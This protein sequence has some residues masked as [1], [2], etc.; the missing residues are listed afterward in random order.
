M[1]RPTSE[2][3]AEA[4]LNKLGGAD[5]HGLTR[6]EVAAINLYTQEDCGVYSRL[7]TALRSSDRQHVKPY[8]RYLRLLLGGLRKLPAYRGSVWRGVKLDLAATWTGFWSSCSW[9]DYLSM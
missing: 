4:H 6:D 2:Q 5:P 9:E 7:N 8:F 1:R 3:F